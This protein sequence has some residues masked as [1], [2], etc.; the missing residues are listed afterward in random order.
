MKL[1]L[2]FIR[3]VQIKTTMRN[4][5][6][7]KLVAEIT[8]TDHIKCLWGCRVM[9][10]LILC[11]WGYKLVQTFWK[12]VCHFLKT[13]SIYLPDPVTPLLGMKKD[14]CIYSYKNLSTNVVHSNFICNSQNLVT[15]QMSTNRG[16]G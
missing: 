5:Y 6:I 12:P 7:P 14:E 16:K 2:L 4:Y 11:W 13:L 8:K 9:E 3:E 10:A 15:T 1:K